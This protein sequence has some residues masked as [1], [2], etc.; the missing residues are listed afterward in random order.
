MHFFAQHFF[1]ERFFA[2]LQER[3]DENEAPEMTEMGARLRLKTQRVSNRLLNLLKI[4]QCR[5]VSLG[6]KRAFF[7]TENFKKTQN[8]PFGKKLPS[9]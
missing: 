1:R 7:L 3:N 2:S 8:T 9:A 6:L 5:K 4:S